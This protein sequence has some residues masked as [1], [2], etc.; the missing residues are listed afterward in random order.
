MQG[1]CAWRSAAAR[2]PHEARVAQHLDACW[3]GSTSGTP[4]E[5]DRRGRS[6]SSPAG[7]STGTCPPRTLWPTL[8]SSSAIKENGRPCASANLRC[9]SAL[10]VDTPMT[11]TRAASN[12][13][14]TSRIA[15][16]WRVQPAGCPWDRSTPAKAGHREARPRSRGGRPPSGRAR[17]PPPRAAPSPHPAA[18][19]PNSRPMPP[20]QS[21]RI[22]WGQYRRLRQNATPRPGRLW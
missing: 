22:A 5:P 4:F 7:S 14:Q 21:G 6:G 8:R 2:Q 18:G 20:G 12:F 19:S 15:H 16:A 17:P 1:A 9:D 13:C 10:S 11:R 3:P